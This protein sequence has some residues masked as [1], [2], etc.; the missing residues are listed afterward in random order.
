MAMK[1]NQTTTGFIT[2]DHAASIRNLSL[3]ARLIVEGTMAGLHQS[4]YHGFSSEFLE[5]RP[6]FPG[7]SARRIDWRKY[8]KSKRTVIRLFEDETNLFAAILV[9]KSASMRFSSVSA[10]NKYDYARTLAASLAW[11]LIGQRDA[12]GLYAFD[13]KTSLS[14]PPRST[15]V[16]LQTILAHLDA[17]TP[18]GATRCGEALSRLA[19]PLNK[20]GLCIVI[21]DLFDDADDIIRGL[22]H[23]RFKKQDVIVLRISD[24]MEH[25]FNGTSSLRIRDMETGEEILLDAQTAAR[26]YNA[27][28]L[29][30]KNSIERACRDLRIDY[31]EILTTEPFRKA[32]VRVLDKRRRLF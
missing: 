14:V 16:Q 7:E 1:N 20:R 25:R 30:H 17:L 19:A 4:P 15:R 8:A 32:L 3:R 18:S 27:G 5:Y 12:V 22:R 11:I 21:S 9:D 31:E 29:S 10:M 23:L 24:P 2:P 13:E 6:Y 28:N 26:F